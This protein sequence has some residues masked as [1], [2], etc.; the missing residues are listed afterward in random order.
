M[1]GLTLASWL[2][3]SSLQGQ[4][5]A[6]AGTNLTALDRPALEQLGEPNATTFELVDSWFA[7]RPIQYYDFGRD[8]ARPTLLY[9]V[10]GGSD[11]VTTLPGL[12]GYSALRAVYVLEPAPGVDASAVRS[13]AQI[14]DLLRRG[15]ARLVG[16]GTVINAPIV[17]QGSRLDR[18]PAERMVRGAWYK[19]YRI[20]YYDLGPVSGVPIPL[21]VFV[22]GF[23][24]NGGVPVDA[25]PSN[26]SAVPGVP[27]YSDM[28]QIRFVQVGDRFEPGSYRDHRRALADARSGRFQ[29]ID[30]GMVVNCPVMYVDGRPAAR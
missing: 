24:E 23:D 1:R 12:Q 20:S 3:A 9:R 30:S 11:V 4:V 6:G 8:A 19:G 25:Q 15:L 26:A 17:P 10:R 22:S 29:I 7:G 21:I 18:D 16:P 28:W 5:S 13:H 2:A 14:E 27:G